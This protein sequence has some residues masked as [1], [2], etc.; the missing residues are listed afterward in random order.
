[1]TFQ[2]VYE[3]DGTVKREE[4]NLLRVGVADGT[5]EPMPLHHDSMGDEHQD[6]NQAAEESREEIELPRSQ[7]AISQPFGAIHTR[8]LVD[9][10]H[11]RD[12]ANGRT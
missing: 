6:E 12:T 10:K 7:T 9:G 2:Y 4:Y 8:P 11:P 5:D 1:M 3:C